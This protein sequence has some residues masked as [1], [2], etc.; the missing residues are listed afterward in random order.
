MVLR[1]LKYRIIELATLFILVA[2]FTYADGSSSVS[3][4][5]LISLLFYLLSLYPFLKTLFDR[6]FRKDLL[7]KSFRIFFSALFPVIYFP[8]ALLVFGF[9][10]EEMSQRAFVD[11]A[12]F[13]TILLVFAAINAHDVA[14][15]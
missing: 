5:L 15:S 7:R 14:T 13:P 6:F 2:I 12:L 4:S 8:V 1:S 11:S 10:V 9:S 3:G